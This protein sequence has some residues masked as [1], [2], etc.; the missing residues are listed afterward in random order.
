MIL[1]IWVSQTEK[2][3]GVYFL[4]LNG[5]S[6]RVKVC[7]SQVNQTPFSFSPLWNR[8][9]LLFHPLKWKPWHFLI[10]GS[11]RVHADSAAE[12]E[13]EISPM[14]TGQM[15]GLCSR[16]FITLSMNKSLVS[17]TLGTKGTYDVLRLS[18]AQAREQVWLCVMAVCVRQMALCLLAWTYTQNNVQLRDRISAPVACRGSTPSGGVLRGVSRKA[19]HNGSKTRDILHC[20]GD[21]PVWVSRLFCRSSDEK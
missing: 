8:H 17:E 19:D 5:G 18:F 9:H 10:L 14:I 12:S 11:T 16:M 2:C 7:A 20:V 6:P 21:E 13:S 15:S 3:K 4:T 1:E